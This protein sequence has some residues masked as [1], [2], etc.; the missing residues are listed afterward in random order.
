MC[1]VGIALSRATWEMG[2]IWKERAVRTCTFCVLRR[3]LRTAPPNTQSGLAHHKLR[4]R[5][6]MNRSQPYLQASSATSARMPR[7]RHSALGSSLPGPRLSTGEEPGRMLL[8]RR[9]QRPRKI[10]WSSRNVGAQIII[11]TIFFGGG[12]LI[13][14]IV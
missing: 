10:S 12:L 5:L 11:F 3:N 4:G 1:I 8:M 7:A 14:M 13:L 9:D 6:M 2:S